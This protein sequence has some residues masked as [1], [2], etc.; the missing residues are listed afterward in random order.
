MSRRCTVTLDASM[1][2]F[3]ISVAARNKKMSFCILLLYELSFA[4]T[5][6][7]YFFVSGSLVL[8]I[9]GRKGSTVDHI[10]YT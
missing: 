2:A 9:L 7:S 3:T 5:P 10:I 1:F 8:E 4:L 6:F